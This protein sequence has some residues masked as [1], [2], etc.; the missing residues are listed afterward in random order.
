VVE[1][2][3]NEGRFAHLFKPGNE[4]ILEEIQADVDRKW[5]ELLYREEYSCKL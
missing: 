2:L 5:N 3:K 1:Y 4:K